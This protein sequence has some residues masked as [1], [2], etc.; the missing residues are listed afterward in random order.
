MNEKTPV[1]GKDVQSQYPLPPRTIE[2]RFYL[3]EAQYRREM[4]IIFM[5]TWLPACSSKELANPRDYVVWDR[6]RQSVVIVRQLDGSLKAW[7][8]VCQHRGARLV[9]KSGSCRYGKF[10]CPWHGFSYDLA[11]VCTG[12]PLR[13][14]FDERELVGR[15]PGEGALP[16]RAIR[17]LFTRQLWKSASRFRCRR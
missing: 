2:A 6:L 3:D 13:E 8:N 5:Q 14:S 10:K 16:S 7:H 9:D 15:S 12:V 17:H 11:G 4:E 1:K